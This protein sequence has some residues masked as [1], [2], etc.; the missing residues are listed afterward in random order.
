MHS[1]TRPR[2]LLRAG[3]L[4]LSMVAIAGSAIARLENEPP[5]VQTLFVMKHAAMDRWLVDAKDQRFA[6]ALKMLPARLN[7]LPKESNGQFNEQAAGAINTIIST[8]ARPG[9]MAIT[10]NAGNVADGLY[11]YG[12]VFSADFEDQKSEIGRAHV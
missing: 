5:K 3:L 6:D 7:E 4:G 11:N 1:V 10:L 2:Q 8:L 12:I 9:H